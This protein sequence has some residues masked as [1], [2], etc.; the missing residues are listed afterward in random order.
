MTHL[1]RFLR[2]WGLIFFLS[3]CSIELSPSTPAPRP[4]IAAPT[5][6][7]NQS[8]NASTPEAPAWANLNLSGQL[9]VI[10]STFGNKG[11]QPITFNLAALNL[12]SGKLT[13]LFHAP[14]QAWV[15]SA[16]VSPDHQ[17]IVIA[18][19]PP[20]TPGEIQFGYSGLYQ[21]PTESAD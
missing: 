7:A 4:S 2:L 21:L 20:P 18:Y 19:A 14:D 3:A 17:T 1:Q 16:A 9:M 11:V 5:I 6:T 10:T 13:R 12:D 8:S 15:T